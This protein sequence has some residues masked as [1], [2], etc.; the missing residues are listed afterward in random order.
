MAKRYFTET[1]AEVKLSLLGERIVPL[2]NPS[3]RQL[4]NVPYTI[5]SVLCENVLT[6]YRN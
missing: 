3:Q 5:D 1:D 6:I 4:V 2:F